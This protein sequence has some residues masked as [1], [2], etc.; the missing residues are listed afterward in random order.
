MEAYPDLPYV[1]PHVQPH[2]LKRDL[3]DDPCA[4]KSSV[5]GAGPSPSLPAGTVATGAHHD[6]DNEDD[7][8]LAV[9][10]MVHQSAAKINQLKRA[11][12]DPNLTDPERAVKQKALQTHT[13]TYTLIMG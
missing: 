12:K 5:T 3:P 13:P 6:P 10:Q 2:A 11:F 4:G 7:D 9:A 8:E 1:S